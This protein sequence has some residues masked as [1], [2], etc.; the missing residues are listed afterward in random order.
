MSLSRDGLSALLTF[1]EL[2]PRETYTNLY[3]LL[4]NELEKIQG[5]NYKGNQ[6][7]WKIANQSAS[8]Q[9]QP[10][11]VTTNVPAATT[12]GTISPNPQKQPLSTTIPSLSTKTSFVVPII[13]DVESVK[14]WKGKLNVSDFQKDD[15]IS[16]LN[17]LI[18]P[19]LSPFGIKLVFGEFT[20]EELVIQNSL[21]TKPKYPVV[22]FVADE[23][24][25]ELPMKADLESDLRLLS[26]YGKSPI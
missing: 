15:M 26:Y 13:F 3:D 14:T 12:T 9:T 6:I 21:F 4:V 20:K 24:R 22:G 5:G 23:S 11:T 7:D 1:Y 17:K 18:K 2:T 16:A 8:L 25:F 19:I 10:T